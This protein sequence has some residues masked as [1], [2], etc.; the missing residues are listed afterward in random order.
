MNGVRCFSGYI[1]PAPG[2]KDDR[3]V[4]FSV[5]TNNIPGNSSTVYAILDEI[6]LSL[7]AEP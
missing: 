2:E 7:A 5:L 4:V 1:L 3:T 6:I